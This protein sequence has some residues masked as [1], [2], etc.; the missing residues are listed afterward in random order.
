MS[1]FKRTPKIDPNCESEICR[2]REISI[3]IIEKDLGI[4]N[5]TRIFMG[6]RDRLDKLIDCFN[7]LEDEASVRFIQSN[8]HIHDDKT[9]PIEKIKEVGEKLKQV[10]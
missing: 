7:A 3:K 5:I 1:L 2:R 10:I 4:P 6:N 8:L 9:T